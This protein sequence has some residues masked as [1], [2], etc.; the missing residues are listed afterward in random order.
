[1]AIIGTTNQLISQGQLNRLRGS[2]QFADFP[3]LNV[4]AP[5]LAKGGIGMRRTTAATDTIDTMTGF[6]ISPA[7]F[8][9]VEVTI[10]MLYTQFL[11]QQFEQ[12]FQTDT[13]IGGVT[14][15]L[16]VNVTQNAPNFPL[17][18][19]VLMNVGDFRIDGMSGEYSVTLHGIYY[20]NSA[21]FQ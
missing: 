15:R 13:T 1:V 11:A 14:V 4:T 19:S 21:L 17:S 7:P 3:N 2:V 5:Y 18:N 16:D 6:V 8:V 12:Q 10:H 9:H 20:V